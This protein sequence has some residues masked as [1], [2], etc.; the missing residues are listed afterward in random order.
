MAY[1]T[2]MND[3]IKQQWG[4]SFQI[5]FLF[6]KR[7]DRYAKGNTVS[8]LLRAKQRL[9]LHSVSTDKNVIKIL[10]I[11]LAQFSLYCKRINL[12]HHKTYRKAAVNGFL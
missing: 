9:R 8:G 12:S 7:V 6:G 10:E 1:D 5:E 11:N 4:N 3:Y 2:N